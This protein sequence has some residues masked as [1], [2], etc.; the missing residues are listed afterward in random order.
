ML[1][2]HRRLCC[3][4]TDLSSSYVITSWI[5]STAT[6]W[7]CSTTIYPLQPGWAGTR[8]LRNINPIYHPLPI[9][10]LHWMCR[11]WSVNYTTSTPDPFDN[12]KLM[13]ES[14]KLLRPENLFLRKLQR[15][16]GLTP[17]PNPRKTNTKKL[18]QT[19]IRHHTY[20]LN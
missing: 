6:P 9:C 18:S 8:T 20:Q 19:I 4:P 5:C 12:N 14:T 11:T 7:I 15:Y 2:K 13:V 16:K 3:A 1:N 17:N 10:H